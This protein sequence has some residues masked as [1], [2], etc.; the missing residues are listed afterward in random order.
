MCLVVLKRGLTGYPDLKKKQSCLPNA[1]FRISFPDGLLSFS[2]IS[3]YEDTRDDK[4]V[5]GPCLLGII[6]SRNCA[7]ISQY[8]LPLPRYTFT[9][10]VPICLSL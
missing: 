4:K 3:S 7:I 5:L 6:K 1:S 9:F 10:A 8:N 2:E